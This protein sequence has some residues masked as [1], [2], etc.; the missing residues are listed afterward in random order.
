MA[1]ETKESKI[2]KP[3]TIFVGVSKE[4]KKK[5][6]EY[7]FNNHCTVPEA[8]RNAVN[9]KISSLN[10]EF[11]SIT[12]NLP[13]KFEELELNDLKQL[14]EARGV[15]LIWMLNDYIKRSIVNEWI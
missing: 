9:E 11:G 15:D 14:A 3:I 8:V 2:E 4:E 7:A 1:L 13:L 12:F 5:W 6:D 10:P